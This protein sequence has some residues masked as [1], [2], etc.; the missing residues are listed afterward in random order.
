MSHFSVHASPMDFHSLDLLKRTMS[1]RH[2][3][4]SNGLWKATQGEWS[5]KDVS[6]LEVCTV[7][8]KQA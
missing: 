3:R 4:T 1:K 7:P 8:A 5:E 2:P 6:V